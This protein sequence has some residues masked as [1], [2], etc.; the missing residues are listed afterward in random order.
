MFRVKT[1][2]AA[3][4]NHA[5]LTPTKG[6]PALYTLSGTPQIISAVLTAISTAIWTAMS[7]ASVY[8]QDSWKTASPSIPVVEVDPRKMTVAFSPSVESSDIVEGDDDKESILVLSAS[9]LDVSFHMIDELNDT[10]YHS[11]LDAMPSLA[12]NAVRESVSSLLDV[13]SPSPFGKMLSKIK[14]KSE[15]IDQ[16][17]PKRSISSK[18]FRK[19]MAR[20]S[21]QP[22]KREL[23]NL[24]RADPAPI[25]DHLRS[26]DFKQSEFR[27]SPMHYSILV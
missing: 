20:L 15:K 8:S 14:S 11:K 4:A 13:R 23:A 19:V 2:L 24:Q 18:P 5:E 6:S 16:H 9:P 27:A 22:S 1:D 7:S 17:G 3:K 10:G 21:F 12:N 25:S 26:L